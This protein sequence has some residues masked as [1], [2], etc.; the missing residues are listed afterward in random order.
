MQLRV[1]VF[2]GGVRLTTT[3]GPVLTSVILNPDDEEP[4]LELLRQGFADARA[5]RNGY[6]QPH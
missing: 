5:E 2:E 6:V 3:Y 1:D 4:V